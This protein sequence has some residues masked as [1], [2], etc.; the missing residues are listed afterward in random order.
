MGLVSERA[1]KIVEMHERRCTNHW[2]EITELNQLDYN[3]WCSNISQKRQTLTQ[4]TT[5][6]SP[7]GT[8]TDILTFI[9]TYL[10]VG[11]IQLV[12]QRSASL[13]GIGGIS[14]SGCGHS[15]HARCS[16]SAQLLI[17]L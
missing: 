17:C 4:A 6:S 8:F 13:W 7:I 1:F 14:E 12:S 10:R 5:H 15:A 16:G 9:I 11:Q 2:P 3:Y